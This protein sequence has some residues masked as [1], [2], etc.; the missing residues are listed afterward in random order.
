[1]TREWYSKRGT[2]ATGEHESTKARKHESTK[3][4]K[5]ESK[6]AR[7]HE[8]KKARKQESTKA[9]K[10]ENTKTCANHTQQL[11]NHNNCSMFTVADG[12]FKVTVNGVHVGTLRQDD[13]FG[14]TSLL[15]NRPRSATVACVSKSGCIAYEMMNE[16]FRA[17]LDE[18]ADIEES[19]RDLSRRREFKKALRA[20][21]GGMGVTLKV[22]MPRKCIYNYSLAQ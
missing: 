9:R 11:T 4:R 1:M 8:S 22:R 10:H 15:M 16:D 7:K 21:T 17:L 6:K 12:E 19:L 5:H 3:A 14:E 2:Q 13:M 18:S 20:Q